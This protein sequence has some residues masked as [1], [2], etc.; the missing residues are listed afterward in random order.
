MFIVPLFIVIAAL[1]IAAFGELRV[2]SIGRFR[3]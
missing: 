2:T 3:R 1:V